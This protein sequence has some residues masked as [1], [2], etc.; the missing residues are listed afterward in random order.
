MKDYFKCFSF[1]KT[2]VFDFVCLE[3]LD[4]NTKSMNCCLEGATV[5][6]TFIFLIESVFI[7]ILCTMNTLTSKGYQNEK[8]L[9]I[10]NIF[11]R[12]H[13]L[14]DRFGLIPKEVVALLEIIKIKQLCKISNINKVDVGNNGITLC[15]FKNR[16]SN[17]E[18][19]IEF[20]SLNS[21]KINVKPDQSIVI[22]KDLSNKEN[23]VESV[24]DELKTIGGLVN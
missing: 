13:E 22:F 2:I 1:A 15:F 16:F 7:S 19:L 17:P 10:K 3:I 11:C 18:K 24:K 12:L 8:P 23:R 9:N 4:A 6:T 14:N 5:V 20:I 21:T